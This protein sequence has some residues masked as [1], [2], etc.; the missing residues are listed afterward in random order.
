MQNKLTV[1]VFSSSGAPIKKTTI[2][3]TLIKLTVM[4]FLVCLGGLG[5]V[6]FDYCNLKAI[7]TNSI[8]LSDLIQVQ[9]EDIGTQRQQ[10]QK[11]ADEI[12]SLKSKIAELNTFEKKIRV[13]A[14]LEN[15]GET[16]DLFGVGGSIPEDLDT[17][18]ELTQKHNSLVREMHEQTENLSLATIN[19]KQG[20]NLLLKHLEEQKNLLASTPT[21][22]PAK[23]WI[24]SKFGYRTSPF[25]GRRE[26]H[27]G[28]DIAAR[29]GTPVYA[30]AEGIVTYAKVK[31]LLG[32]TI[33]I[34]H[35]HGMVTRF[36]HLNKILV[37]HGQTVQ[38]GD[39]IG[40]IGNTG[41]STGPHLHY[42]VRLN[43]LPVNPSIYIMN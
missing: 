41:R 22:A 43:G 39:N 17:G 20:F 6:V 36:G 10:I 7:H 31:G 16:G 26:F 21:I 3:K 28:L 38:R 42:E 9:Q 4:C 25:T 23:G 13:I 2:S 15:Q 33:V 34:D 27:K 29:R 35:G 12:N 37:S 30:T 5:Y 14:N 11:F 32:R 8:N 1:F 24:T 19:Q 18:V 40:S